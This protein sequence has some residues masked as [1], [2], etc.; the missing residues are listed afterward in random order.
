MTSP[1]SLEAGIRS[2]G[3]NHPLSHSIESG[4]RSVSSPTLSLT[5]SQKV[6]NPNK[7]GAQYIEVHSIPQPGKPFFTGNIY[8]EGKSALQEAKAAT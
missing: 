2:E 8:K 6:S 1:Q 4:R 3:A 7:K 5:A